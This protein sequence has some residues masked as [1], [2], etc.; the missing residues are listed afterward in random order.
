MNSNRGGTVSLSPTVGVIFQTFLVLPPIVHR[1]FFSGLQTLAESQQVSSTQS[2][3]VRQQDVLFDHGSA[4]LITNN[5][6]MLGV[7]CF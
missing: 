2:G 3:E 7:Y 4:V 5:S 1:C 6:V